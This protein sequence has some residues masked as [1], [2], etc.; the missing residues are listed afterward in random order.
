MKENE[1]ALKVLAVE[2]NRLC[3]NVFGQMFIRNK[4]TNEQ[5]KLIEA[6]D[7]LLALMNGS[8]LKNEWKIEDSKDYK[9]LVNLTKTINSLNVG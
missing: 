9:E 6:N 7:M 8:P 2:Y 5:L 3:G 1:V 4:A